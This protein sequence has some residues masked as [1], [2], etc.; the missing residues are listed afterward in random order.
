MTRA[1]VV[2]DRLARYA[3]V[4]F[5]L[6]AGATAGCRKSTAEDSAQI[7]AAVGEVMSSL[8]ESAQ[9]TTT[10]AMMPGVP[11]LRTPEQLKGPLWRRLLGRVRPQAYAASCATV[12]FSTCTM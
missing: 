2:L 5:V 3:V 11:M 4:F 8:D 6:S 12:T 7:G 9:G 1:H 10:T